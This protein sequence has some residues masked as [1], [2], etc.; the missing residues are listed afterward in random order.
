MIS[1]AKACAD[2]GLVTICAFPSYAR[3]DRAKVRNRIGEDRFVEVYVNTDASL[4]RERRPDADHTG[5]EAPQQPDVTVSLERMRNREA[6]D[7]I[8]KAL[9]QRGE[10]D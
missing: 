4:C 3:A 9:T 5:F 8:L 6:V 2:A 1:A 10:F 7:L